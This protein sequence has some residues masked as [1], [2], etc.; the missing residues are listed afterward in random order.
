M[1]SNLGSQ[2]IQEKMHTEGYDKVKE[3]V[4]QIVLQH[5]RP[6]FINRVDETVIFEPLNEEMIKQIATIQINRVRKTSG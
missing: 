6:E 5:F 1:T 2:L 4:M 3:A